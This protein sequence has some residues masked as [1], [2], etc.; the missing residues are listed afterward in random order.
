MT[1]ILCTDHSTNLVRAKNDCGFTKL[2]LRQ[3]KSKK[4]KEKKKTE[5]NKE[6]KKREEKIAEIKR[7]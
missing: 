3:R 1:E 7:V 5:E 2:G 6:K 4:K